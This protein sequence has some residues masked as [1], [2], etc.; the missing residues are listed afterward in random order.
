MSNNVKFI[1]FDFDGVIADSFELAFEI[2][3]HMCPNITKEDYRKL[4]EGNI[5]HNELPER[6]HSDLCNHDIDFFDEYIPEMKHKVRMFPSIDTVVTELGETYTLVVIS[7]TPSGPIAEFLKRHDLEQC[8]IKIM[9]KD[10]HTSKVE[11]IQM[12]FDAYAVHNKDCVFI[13]DTL[14]D[15]EEAAKKGVGA[16]AVTWGFHDRATLKKGNPFRL[17]DTPASISD[18]V[19]DF[20]AL[21]KQS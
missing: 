6:V 21:G 20:F 19:A 2:N 3:T 17:V 12:V 9:G 4:F 15:I 14:G 10:V 13:T 11:K 8:F 18:A 1:L 7:S 16:I 5:Y